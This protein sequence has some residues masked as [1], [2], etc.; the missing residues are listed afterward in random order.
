[1]SK[2]LAKKEEECRD[3]AVMNFETDA[4][5][6]QE[7]AD[8][9]SFAIPYLTVLQKLSPQLDSDSGEYIEGAKAGDLVQTVTKEVFRGKD[10][11]QLIP[12]HFTRLFT[13]WVP[14]NQGGGFR[15]THSPSDP[16][17]ATGMRDDTGKLH[18]ENGNILTDTRYHYCILLT[19]NGPQPVMVSFTSSQ[20]KKSKQW[21]TIMRTLKMVG[22]NGRPFTPPTYSHI[23]RLVT[24][25]QQNS[26]GAWSGVKISMERCLDASAADD[27]VS[28]AAAREFR[29]M[30][31]AGK[32]E[33]IPVEEEDEKESS[34]F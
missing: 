14:R 29:D 24:V 33:I 25:P 19:D 21:M 6:G 30:V 34:D 32:T 12:V 28:Y 27:Q 7:E 23:Y 26:K 11:V 17:V 5:Q 15:G 1:M 18:I 22:K 10:G 9:D 2:E 13:E 4:G 3:L 20:I 31:L 16:L 8:S